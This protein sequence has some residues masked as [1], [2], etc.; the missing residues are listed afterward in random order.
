MEDNV[1]P[2]A[3][4]GTIA[5]PSGIRRWQLN[6]TCCIIST[7]PSR[8]KHEQTHSSPQ[9]HTH[10]STLEF[11]TRGRRRIELQRQLAFSSHGTRTHTHTHLCPFLVV[12]RSLQKMG[13]HN[14]DAHAL[15]AA[16]TCA[17]GRDQVNEA[18]CLLHNPPQLHGMSNYPACADLDP[19]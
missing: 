5:C 9:T 2:I 6:P 15:K 13:I 19:A 4:C 10:I 3:P 1:H 16:G 17:R 7:P 14:H 18:G 12:K 11:T 8:V